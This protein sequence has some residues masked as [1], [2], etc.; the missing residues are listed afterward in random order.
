MNGSTIEPPVD[1]SAVRVEKLSGVSVYK[2][3]DAES[4]GTLQSYN[5][6]VGKNARKLD[7]SGLYTQFGRAHV[8]GTIPY[9]W[10]AGHFEALL[11]RATF[12]E[13][14]AA[15]FTGAVFH[16]GSVPGET[17]AALAK[18][19]L[20]INSNID[21]DTP[22][23]ESLGRKGQVALVCECANEWELVIP[24]GLLENLR[25][26]ETVV[27][28]FRRHKQLP[29]TDS[30]CREEKEDDDD[31]KRWKRAPMDSE[32]H[33]IPDLEVPFICTKR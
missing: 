19:L 6:S 33:W 5:E 8:L 29:V 2:L 3:I 32:P 11:I 27:A 16:D 26:S 20:G 23:I 21:I 18:E 10:E 17:K 4:G 9:R 31:D 7:W 13:L 1:L 22:L 25:Y 30:W 28:R 12:D 14:D 15:V 24:H